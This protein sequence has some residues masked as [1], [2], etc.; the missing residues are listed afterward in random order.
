MNQKNAISAED[1]KATLLRLFSELRKGKT[2]TID[3]VCSPKFAFRSPISPTGR[4]AW[5]GRER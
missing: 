2:S 5:K 4:A 3:E 1:N